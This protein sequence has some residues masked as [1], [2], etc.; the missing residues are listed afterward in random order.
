[1]T[2]LNSDSNQSTIFFFSTRPSF[3]RSK[4]SPNLLTCLGGMGGMGRGRGGGGGGGGGLSRV[5]WCLRGIAH[6]LRSV[7]RFGLL[8]RVAALAE[9]EVDEEERQLGPVQG[10][11]L[12]HLLHH[13]AHQ[14]PTGA[15][16]APQPSPEEG[17]GFN[18]KAP[19][20]GGEQ[21]AERGYSKPV[22]TRV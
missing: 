16:L 20:R 22:P 6:Q 19:T 4:D 10:P 3:F 18:S 21:S 11:A 12:L 17:G 14:W 1:M 8:V 15:R 7:E 13:M 9:S 2:G 5:Q